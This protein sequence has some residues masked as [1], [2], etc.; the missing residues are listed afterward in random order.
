MGILR[1]RTRRRVTLLP[2]S[3]RS[4]RRDVA[5]PPARARELTEEPGEIG[6]VHV[7]E[8]EAI[9]GEPRERRAL[10]ANRAPRR[11]DPEAVSAV[12]ARDYSP[13]PMVV[14]VDHERDPFE[15]EVG[16]GGE[17]RRGSRADGRA[18]PRF[19]RATTA[20]SCAFDAT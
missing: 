20:W 8:D 7:L 2:T 15:P 6:T 1:R 4:D 12:R 16:E 13:I 11:R 14:D 17:E 5:T 18:T 10:D 3:A 9:G 19:D